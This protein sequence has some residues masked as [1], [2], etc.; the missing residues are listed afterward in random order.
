MCSF[1]VGLIRSAMTK[2]V[3]MV[4]VAVFRAAA[5]PSLPCLL[6]NQ[7]FHS[8]DATLQEN[9]GLQLVKEMASDVTNMM[10]FKV[11]AVNV[12]VIVVLVQSLP[13][14]QAQTP[15]TTTTARV[16]TVAHN[17]TNV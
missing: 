5:P 15:T 2:L 12:S 8:R 13:R 4:E 9:D 1:R 11:D 10:K 17:C 14:F 7:N 3:G 16:T 6:T